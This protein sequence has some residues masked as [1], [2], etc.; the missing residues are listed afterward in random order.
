MCSSDQGEK[1]SVKQSKHQ[2]EFDDVTDDMLT[3]ADN[4][5]IYDMWSAHDDDVISGVHPLTNNVADAE[6]AT[7]MDADHD[8]GFGCDDVDW[9]DD[10]VDDADLLNQSE[11][12]EE[13]ET[14]WLSAKKRKLWRHLWLNIYV[15]TNFYRAHTKYDAKVMFSLFLSFCSQGGCQNFKYASSIGRGGHKNL[16]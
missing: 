11:P 12:Q 13:K 15:A 4:D 14:P 10:G 6:M 5:V 7:R 1:D 3:A 8:E 2:T 16:F 9:D